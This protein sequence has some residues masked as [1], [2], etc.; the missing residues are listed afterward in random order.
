MQQIVALLRTHC[1]KKSPTASALFISLYIPMVNNF[2]NK[3]TFLVT[4][5]G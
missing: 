3:I 5:V 4:L 1:N 2:F